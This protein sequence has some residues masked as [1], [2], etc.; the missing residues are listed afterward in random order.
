MA[1][2]TVADMVVRYD[3]RILGELV[4]DD[5]TRIVGE[6]LEDNAKLLAILNTASGVINASVLRAKRYTVADLESL[7]GVDEA[8]LVDITCAIAWWYLW[9]RKPQAETQDPIR[10]TAQKD[11][12]QWLKDLRSGE[13]IFNVEDVKEAGLPE[14]KIIDRATIISRNMWSEQLR[15]RLTPMRRFPNTPPQ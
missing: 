11:A 2:A 7:T 1:Y 12:E 9:R 6:D 14:G 3:E 13:T 8:T 10:E 5:S 4:S 15:G